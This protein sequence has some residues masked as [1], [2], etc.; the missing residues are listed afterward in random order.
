MR[1]LKYCLFG[2]LFLCASLTHAQTL[3]QFNG[4]FNIQQ[5]TAM[6]VDQYQIKGVFQDQSNIFQ[7]REAAVG[8]R[9]IDQNGTMFEVLSLSF[10]GSEIDVV[11]KK[12]GN[13]PAPYLGDGLLYRPTSK[14]F[15]L[16]TNNA[17]LTVMTNAQNTAF[18]SID[19]SIPNY[20]S[21]SV[22]PVS[23]S[24]VGD[25]ILNT[26][27]SKV[28]RLTQSGWITVDNIPYQFGF[29]DNATKGDVITYAMDD[30]NYMYN[31]AT[32]ERL[33]ELSGLPAQSKYGDV[34]YDSGQQ[35]LFMFDANSK[36]LNISGGSVPGGPGTELPGKSK[37]GDLFF[38]TDL[39]KLF[40]FDNNGKWLEASIDGSTPAGTTNPDP[41]T[42]TSVKEGNLFYNSTEHKLY[43]YNGTAWTTLDNTL[44]TGQIYVGNNSNIATSVPMSGDAK[45]SITGKLTIEDLK[46]TEEKLD[47]S[48]IPISG[49]ANPMDHISM[50][51][52][53]TNYRII[54]L[55]T[56]QAGT[57][58]VNKDYVTGLMTNPSLLALA[59]NHLFV[60]NSS[61]K[62][63]AIHKS[64]IP[65]S[66]F[67]K[68]LAN[69][70]MGAGKGLPNFKIVNLADPTAP[71]DAATMNYV[72][73]RVVKG[74]N[75]MLPAGEMF[76][77]SDIGTAAA[78]KKNT[79]SWSEFGAAKAT[80]SIGGFNLTNL[81]DPA[82][83]QDAATKNYVDTK[84]FN[85]SNLSLGA[86]NLFVG[87]A[88]GKAA[89]VLKNT[90]PWSGFAAATANVSLGGFMLTD[91][92][93]PEAD[94]DASTKK[95][96]DDLFKNTSTAL[97]LPLDHMFLGDLAGKAIA[98]PTKNIPLSSF[99][100][101]TKN[102]A[103]GDLT[104]QFGI[105]FLK[106]PESDQ[107]AATMAYVN[108]QV[109]NPA[110]LTLSTD[111]ILVGNGANKASPIA[112]S[113][114]PLSDF[115]AA[116]GHLSIGGFKLINVKDPETDQ[117]AATKKY[118][119]SK[120]SKTPVG[121]TAPS[122]TP[123]AG[124]SYYNTTDNRLYVYNGK[125]WIPVD[126]KLA[127]GHLYVGSPAG[128]A[129]STPKN[130]IPL[131]GFGS[132]QGDVSMGNFKITNLVDPV[133]AQEAATKSY[134][135]SKTTKTPVGPTAPV[136]PVVGDT[137]Y[138]T[139]DKR[140]YVYNG[141]EWVPVGNDK[142]AE[143]HLFVGNTLGV[144]T[145]TPKNEVSLTGFGLPT[146]ALPMNNQKITNLAIP[147]LDMDAANKKYV[148]EG[149]AI[150]T[151]GGKD[152]LGNHQ[153][154]KNLILSVNSISNDGQNGK[155]LSFDVPGNAT[156]GQ[157]L[158][159]NGNLFT[160]SDRRLKDH[161][162]TLGNVLQKIDQIRG[163][164]FEY[165]N[166]HKYVSGSKIGVIA[167]ELQKVYPEMV[168][169][170][171]DGFLK[172]DYTQLTGMLIQAVKEQQKEIEALKNR[173]DRQQEQIN[174]ILEKLNK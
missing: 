52:G 173:M 90:I 120:S 72:D 130:V 109:G 142:L 27:D 96:V 70:S 165:K 8:D 104:T 106:D 48:N 145:A 92:K 162:E 174:S 101:A 54:N 147:T 122:G 168:T 74:D 63:T 47:K 84:I 3:R 149:L 99:A 163:V 80:V 152:N 157:D 126:N 24:K 153:A 88:N 1:Y 156:L 114:I 30:L 9:I 32:W 43:V 150:A 85:P 56:P 159:I 81:K 46:I 41:A 172:V 79:I 19:K 118:V 64:L 108:K 117:D 76:V 133:N 91:V 158:T 15:P 116:A 119:D 26:S 60:G 128:I 36:W 166:K 89:E 29:P 135:D 144:A 167:Q 121:P 111:H 105:N 110:S 44:K 49:F 164:S 11:A 73:T 138:N 38:N 55:G 35:K 4:L 129:V 31:G 154:T 107:D 102:I 34:F 45:I 131:S 61:G 6:G 169:Q 87:D 143:G 14:G 132:A 33:K 136:N 98:T 65:I 94:T 123:T 100:K 68:A 127:D 171:K 69:V 103:M 83:A 25:V 71:Q 134:V 115:A 62:A 28:Y 58:A 151:A 95:Y 148:D 2:F 10:N 141:A 5:V 155:G 75:L 137:Y 82:A 18:L 93:S 57:D 66:G 146:A 59:D 13:S 112:K 97:S 53:S 170:G 17:T 40:V 124:D 7:A 86:G 78:V 67:D 39:N 37:P 21:G 22:L 42:N 12:F 16:V 23:T 113:A 51:N 140:L 77:G 139:T 20:D 161:I 160:P 50:G 125:D